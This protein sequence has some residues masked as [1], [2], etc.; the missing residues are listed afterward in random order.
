M[1]H[2]PE[3]YQLQKMSGE[4]LPNGYPA[5]KKLNSR[6]KL[7]I[8]F[9]LCGWKGVDIA[10]HLGVTQATVSRVL[11]D[12]LAQKH[13]EQEYKLLDGEF[14]ALYPRTIDA[15]RQALNSS[16]EQIQLKAVDI[17]MKAHGKYQH[18]KKTSTDESAEDVVAKLLEA[19]QKT[20]AVRLT[21]E[22]NRPDG[23]HERQV[24]RVIEQ[25]PTTVEDDK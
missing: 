25:V 6:A 22:S 8:S 23:F 10:A 21:V 19:A 9:H 1:A 20:G 16:D 14:R 7:I 18:E 2:N 4:R 12:P 15:L 5:L 13:I 3:K 24:E 11:N 17:W